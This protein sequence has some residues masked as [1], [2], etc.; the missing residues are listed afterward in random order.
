MKEG[1]EKHIDTIH[2]LMQERRVR[3]TALLPVW[4]AAGFALGAATALLGKEAAMACTVAVETAI[5]KHYNDQIR[6]LLERGYDEKELAEVL[7]RHRDEE[8][9]HHD[10]AM[11]AGA[12]RAP[13]YAALSAVIQAGCAVAISIAKKV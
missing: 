13:G 12:E 1:E 8:M 6:Q 10:A 9:E 5:S 7:R 11:A 3:P 4:R 2:R